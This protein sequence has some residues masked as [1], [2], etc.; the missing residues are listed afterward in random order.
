MPSYWSR[1]AGRVCAALLLFC[2]LLLPV[3]AAAAEGP[4]AIPRDAAGLPLWQIRVYD[5]FPVRI[6]LESPEELD[7]LLE[8]VPIASFDRSQ[9]R[10]LPLGP[11]AV[12][13]VFEPRVT[14]AEARA[15]AEA[16]YALER[17][18]DLEREGRRAMEAAWAAQA[19][20]GAGA[21]ALG[22]KGVYH[23]H[24]QIGAILQQAA[25]DFPA[26]AAWYSLG[27]SVQGRA[28][29][30]IKITDNVDISEAEP[31]VRL[32]STMHGDEPPGLEMLLYL[33]EHL[34]VNYGVD[35][36]VTDLVDNYEIHIIPCLNPDGLTAGT[37]GN[38]NGR[39]LNRNYPVPDGT[40]GDDGTYSEEI[41][42]QLFKA[43]GQ[44]RKFVVSENGHSGALVVNYP[45]DY[46]YA[47]T[48]DDAAIR[49]LS[50]EYSSRNLPMYN[51]S[52]FPQGITNG[53]QWYVVHG[54]LQDWSY[55]AT[56]CIDV[57]IELSNTKTPPASTLETL[58]D[59]NRESLL[60]LIKAARY[61]VNGR[62]T[63]AATGQPLAAAVTVTGNAKTVTTDP[64]HGD[65][66]KLLPTGTFE[67]TFAAAGHITQTISGV[68][69]VWGTPVVLDVQL[70]EI[71]HGD[72][73]GRVRNAQG[74][75]LSATI[76]I[77]TWP[78]DELVATVQSDAGSGGA[79][80]AR[81]PY[82]NYTFRAACDGYA[83]RTLQVTV[84]DPDETVDITLN[85]SE[86]VLLLADDFESGAGNWSGAWGLATAQAHS[87][88]HSMADSPI[89]NYGHN[90]DI[91]CA[92]AAP[93]NL[94]TAVEG[95]LT[96]WARWNLE[97][98]WDCVQLEISTDGGGAWTAVAA[99]RTVPASG[100]GAQQP[101]GIP[102]YEGN[103]NSWVQETVDL[104]PWLGQTDVRFRFRLRSDGSVAYDGFYFDDL[105]LKVTR[106]AV[107]GV[108]DPPAPRALALGCR[109]NPFN[110]SATLHFTLPAAGSARLAVHDMQGRL[111]RTLVAGALPAGE[112][113]VRWDGRDQRGAPV[114]SGMYLARLSAGGQARAVKL[115]LAR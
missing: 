107:T 69:T 70:A 26:I 52:T 57:T 32:A 23:T 30:A 73:A 105:E 62:V 6:Q 98:N 14:E 80:T 61:G 17:L 115:L 84:D 7:L 92:M 35:P 2:L 89:G 60:H 38:A 114:A 100:Q 25:A 99:T 5:D 58:W 85:A 36:L 102:V 78:T 22:E 50:L 95:T 96:Y 16:G 83:A 75:G 53:A 103:Q 43:H 13:L 66:Y 8:A 94:G 101:A 67:L 51:S 40:I 93:V 12:R 31:E 54:S 21:L 112:H 44:G 56:G 34:T 87:P 74:E 15:L 91:V 20:K 64:A 59:N 63:S 55:H 41:E 110:P 113:A 97:L 104:Q 49:L 68:A 65:Y 11:K 76:T 33:V 82:G 19:A 10:P 111:V 4:T 27:N 86:I 79:Y 45:W 47:L 1:L 71:A 81:L 46:T 77:R 72:V 109:P 28:L 108:G 39:D 90:A 18:P 9:V 29:W 37:R 42:T 88:T 48:P 24:A 3:A 106:E